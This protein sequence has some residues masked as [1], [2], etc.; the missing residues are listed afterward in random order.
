MAIAVPKQFVAYPEA[1]GARQA[2][3]GVAGHEQVVRALVGIG[4]THQAAARA[5]RF[6]LRIAAGDQ[7]VRIDLMARIPDE[8]VAAEVE[9][10]VQ[11]EA[12]ARRR[13]G[14]WRSAPAECS[15]RTSSS[16]ISWAELGELLIG[17]LMQVG[18]GGDF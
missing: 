7:F 18:R 13:P 9:S 3:S 2:A 1:Q 16:R 11:G 6:E 10:E 14:C 12:A 17:E 5:N 4:V 15:A 8:A